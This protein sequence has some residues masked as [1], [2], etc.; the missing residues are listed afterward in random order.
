[1]E[2]IQIVIGEKLLRAADQAAKKT[3]QN[4]SALI[5]EA[6]REHLKRLRIQ[7]LEERDRQG[8]RKRPEPDDVSGWEREASWP[9]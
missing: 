8:Y 7:E 4:R 9:E 3:S 5:R 6:V 1:M 2:T